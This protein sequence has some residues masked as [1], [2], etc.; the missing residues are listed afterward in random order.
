MMESGEDRGDRG[1]R[2]RRDRENMR[3]TNNV[4]SKMSPIK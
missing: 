1:D 3:I 4:K 2:E